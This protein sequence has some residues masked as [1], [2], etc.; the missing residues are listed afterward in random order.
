M[1]DASSPATRRRGPGRPPADQS[2]GGRE[3]L[4]R[5]ARE[6]IA[7]RGLPRVTLREVAERAG[8]QP[9]LVS[10]HFGSKEGLLQ[11]VVELVAGRALARIRTG[12]AGEGSPEER[13]R[14]FLRAAVSSFGEEPYAARL[15]VEQI[16]FGKEAVIDEFVERFA[17]QNLDVIQ[18]VLEE[19]REAGALREVDP[20]FFMPAVIGTCLFF[21]LSAP[22]LRRLFDI[23]EYTPELAEEFA[24]HTADMILKGIATRREATP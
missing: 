8:V 17:R 12:V 13:V 2:E 22:I 7:E 5:A 19:G 23:E 4:L 1:S 14:A 16:L 11:A 21:F 20:R 15:V 10:Y 24:D 9:A 3:A 6:L 18:D